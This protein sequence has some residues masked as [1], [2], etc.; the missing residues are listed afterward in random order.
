MDD[1][2]LTAWCN[3]NMG[4]ERQNESLASGTKGIKKRLPFG[5]NVRVEL[6][7]PR[8]APSVQ[9]PARSP[10]RI[11]CTVKCAPLKTV[12]GQSNRLNL[13]SGNISPV[14]CQSASETPGNP[15]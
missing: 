3:Q 5:P 12:S 2:K 8:G 7:R 15:P 6:Q 9:T 11:M 4:S 1:T 13:N 14:G 10:P